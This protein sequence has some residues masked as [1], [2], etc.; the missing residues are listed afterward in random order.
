MEESPK[1]SQG[2]F[3]IYH[4]SGKLIPYEESGKKGDFVKKENFE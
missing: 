1:E 3:E 2:D 4:P